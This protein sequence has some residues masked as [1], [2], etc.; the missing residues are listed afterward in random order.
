MAQAGITA[1]C[2]G[3]LYC[4]DSTLTRGQ[5]AIFIDA[6]LLNELQ[7]PTAAY[8]TQASPNTAAPGKVV[9]IALTGNS[10]HFVQGST[11]VAAAPGITPSNITVTSPTSLTVQFTLSSGIAPG[12]S[13]IVV[14]T[15]AE[16]AILPNGFVV[17]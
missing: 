8:L 3:S 17:Q 9:T 15:G 1:G 5:M 7:S 2:G 13:S 14:T 12:P 10:T 11:Q 4:P 16:E 6:G